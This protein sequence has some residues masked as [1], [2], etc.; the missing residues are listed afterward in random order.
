MTMLSRY[1]SELTVR[2]RNELEG[3]LAREKNDPDLVREIISSAEFEQLL[4]GERLRDPAG[5]DV[6]KVSMELTYREAM[7][8]R[9]FVYVLRQERSWARRRKR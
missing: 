6:D 8:L 3:R 4:A 5:L 9:W 7:D 2:V 1:E